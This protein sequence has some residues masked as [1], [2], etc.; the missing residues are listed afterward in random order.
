MNSVLLRN[1]VLRADIVIR[2]ASVGEIETLCE[3]DRDASTLFEQ[4]GLF[5]ELPSG[6]EFAI[7]ERHRWLRSVTAGRA[8]LAVG[9]AGE[10]VG[11]AAAEI[12]D[13][14]FH[15]DQLSVRTKLMRLGVGTALLNAVV[16]MARDSGA[17]ALWLTTYRH[18]A[19]N[20]PFYER[21]GFVVV[22]E[23]EC[24]PGICEILRYERRWLPRPE[25]RVAM[26]KMLAGQA[27][28]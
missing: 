26:W 3:I 15:L 14:Q 2:P 28:E 6:H 20:R 16:R 17:S 5:L 9:A 23:R 25:E 27:L 12:V 7:N 24:S 10:P 19:W 21:R 18:L 13:D 1:E 22:P 11:F 8:L 4:A